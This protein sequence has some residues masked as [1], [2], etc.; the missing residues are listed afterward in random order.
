MV[1]I[2]LLQTTEAEKISSLGEEIAQIDTTPAY[3]IV[4]N[5]NRDRRLVRRFQ[6]PLSSLKPMLARDCWESS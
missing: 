2:Y 4:F 1:P 3:R 5:Q 6:Q